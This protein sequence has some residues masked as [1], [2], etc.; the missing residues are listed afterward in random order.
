MWNRTTLAIL[1][2]LA[3]LC[4][5]HIL[6]FSWMWRISGDDGLK[7]K[8]G[9][10]VGF[11]NETPLDNNSNRQYYAPLVSPVAGR[12]RYANVENFVMGRSAPYLQ[13]AVP[14]NWRV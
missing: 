7:V 6:N 14:W 11:L 9:G 2:L 13:N 1:V 4:V 3:L 5:L 8:F 12:D 10:G